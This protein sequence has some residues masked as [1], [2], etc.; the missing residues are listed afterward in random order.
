MAVVHVK[1]VID[2]WTP[3]VNSIDNLYDSTNAMIDPIDNNPAIISQIGDLSII[4]KSPGFLFMSDGS[5][6][7]KNDIYIVDKL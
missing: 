2:S 7:I 3:P 5:G 4:E 6:K 1:S